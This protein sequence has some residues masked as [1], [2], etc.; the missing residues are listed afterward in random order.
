MLIS[1]T[2]IA[3][4]TGDPSNCRHVRRQ[5]MGGMLACVLALQVEESEW[6]SENAGWFVVERRCGRD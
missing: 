2:L 5:G 6:V 1:L 4:M 3:C